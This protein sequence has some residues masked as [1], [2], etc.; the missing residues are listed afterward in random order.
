VIPTVIPNRCGYTE[1]VPLLK[2]VTIRAPVG[3][4]GWM[5]FG[6]AASESGDHRLALLAWSRY[7]E[8]VP[9]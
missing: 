8:L 2:D 9:V 1:A 6:L 4:G 7:N 3:A 5:N